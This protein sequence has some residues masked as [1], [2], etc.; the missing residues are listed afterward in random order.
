MNCSCYLKTDDEQK[1]IGVIILKRE[2]LLYDVRNYSHTLGSIAPTDNP[3]LRHTI[4]DVGDEGNVDRVLRSFDLAYSQCK[5]MLFP[6]TKDSLIT[7]D[8]IIDDRLRAPHTYGIVLTVPEAFSFTTLELLAK[9][10]HEYMVSAAMADWMLMTNPD[11]AEMYLARK[12]QLAGE[13]ETATNTRRGRIR[14]RM[15]PF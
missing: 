12:T 9:T 8:N 7:G 13:I 1:R 3:H 6:Y 2:Q 5:E 11:K 14:R 15:H 10:I 4:Q